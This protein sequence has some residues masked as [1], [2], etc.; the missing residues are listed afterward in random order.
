[1]QNRVAGAEL[2]QEREGI[3]FQPIAK[4]ACKFFVGRDSPPNVPTFRAQL[5]KASTNA[6]AVLA[7]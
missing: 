2:L 7:D 6:A 3:A 1:M 4:I 5:P